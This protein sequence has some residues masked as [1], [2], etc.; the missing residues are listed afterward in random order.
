MIGRIEEVH[1]KG[2]VVIVQISNVSLSVGDELYV[3]DAETCLR[4]S[5]ESLQVNDVDVQ[6]IEAGHIQEVGIRLSKRARYG[7]EL[8]RLRLPVQG[9]ATQLTLDEAIELPDEDVIE[10]PDEEAIE[11]PD[12]GAIEIPREG[13]IEAPND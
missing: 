10:L 5:V 3:C 7:S 12:E 2:L 11:L 4:V 8:R 13:D 1:F 9:V 6:S